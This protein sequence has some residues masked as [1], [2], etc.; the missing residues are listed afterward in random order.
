MSDIFDGIEELFIERYK[1][2]DGAAQFEGSGERLRRL[3]DEMC[4]TRDS[5]DGEVE[6]CFKAVFPD[7][8][9][10]MLVCKPI[11]LWTLCPH[12]LLPVGF[13]VNIGYIPTGGVLG[14]SKFARIAIIMGRVPIIQEQYT[15]DLADILWDRLKPEGLGVYV[16]GSHG[17]IGCRGVNQDID[18]VTSTLKGS[19]KEDPVVREEFYA[20]CRG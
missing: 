9:D 13:K 1:D 17:C 20:I 15:R 12:H 2:W 6:N 4:W 16:V 11:S 18:I 5:I 14:L 3:I 7:K 8:Y 10:E 19:F